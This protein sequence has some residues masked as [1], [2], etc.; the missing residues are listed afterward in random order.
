M[1]PLHGERQ[2]LRALCSS[3]GATASS[4]GIQNSAATNTSYEYLACNLAYPAKVVH[5]SLSL[6]TIEAYEVTIDMIRDRT[7]RGVATGEMFADRTFRGDCRRYIDRWIG[8]K[9][10]FATQCRLIVDG[11]TGEIIQGYEP[12]MA[13]LG[14]LI[15]DRQKAVQESII[16]E[17]LD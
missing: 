15:A 4:F 12:T 10:F 2:E 13:W 3:I 1:F 7:Q 5:P 16:R 6:R 11:K 14:R 8:Q 9:T 17:K